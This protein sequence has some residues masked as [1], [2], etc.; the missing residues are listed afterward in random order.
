LENNTHTLN[1]QLS[2]LKEK[3]KESET[4]KENELL[5]LKQQQEQESKIS[6]LL[7][8]GFHFISLFFL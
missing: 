2:T 6:F 3:M 1:T 5:Q 4:Q 8:G 7:S